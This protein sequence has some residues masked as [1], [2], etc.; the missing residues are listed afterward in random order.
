MKHLSLLLTNSPHA[1]KFCFSVCFLSFFCFFLFFAFWPIETTT[2]DL[3]GSTHSNPSKSTKPSNRESSLKPGSLSQKSLADIYFSLC[4]FCW[5]KE[6]R[7]CLIDQRQQ[8]LWYDILK[9]KKFYVK[10]LIPKIPE[11]FSIV[12]IWPL[13][14]LGLKGS[15]HAPER[16]LYD[17]CPTP[18]LNLLI[19]LKTSISYYG[20]S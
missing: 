5:P 12:I 14:M 11:E 1:R 8:H 3:Q 10:K 19:S 6:G 16:P 18:T 13:Q 17:A 4:I 15:H 2:T 20:R 7:G 9:N